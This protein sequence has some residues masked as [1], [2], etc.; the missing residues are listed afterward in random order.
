MGFVL[1]RIREGTGDIE[2]LAPSL[3]LD[4]IG[5]LGHSNGGISA[6]GEAAFE[7]RIERFLRSVGLGVSIF[8]DALTVEWIKP[9]EDEE[10]ED[11]W[12][13]G[14]TYWY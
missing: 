4:R 8:D 3:D 2:F 5:V 9:L 11:R 1:E 12:Y 10:L 13:V 14:L 7:E 6:V